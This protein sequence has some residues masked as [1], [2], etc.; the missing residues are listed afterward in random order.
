VNIPRR[1]RRL[2]GIGVGLGA[3]LALAATALATDCTN[4]SK[5]VSSGAQVVINAQTGVVE[6]AT[7]GVRQRIRQ[8]AINPDTGAG[9]HGLLGL[10]FDGDGTPEVSAWDGV[11]PTGHEIPVQAQVNGP[12]DRG[13]TSICAPYPPDLRG[14]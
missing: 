8:G 13:V 3:S 14:G 2:A 7:R 5:P 12:A 10:D 4:A 1:A 11:G 9:F 6:R